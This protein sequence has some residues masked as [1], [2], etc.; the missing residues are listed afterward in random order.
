MRSAGPDL[1]NS[2]S[3]DVRISALAAETGW[4]RIGFTDNFQKEA[5]Q[6]LELAKTRYALGFSSIVELSHA[7]LQSTQASVADV[8]A[9][10][11]YLLALRSLAYARGLLAP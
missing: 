5:A 8:N 11:D 10:F 7:Q 6:A 3:R 4:Q 9:C 1:E 2:I